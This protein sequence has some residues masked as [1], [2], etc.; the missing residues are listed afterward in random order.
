MNR[1][2]ALLGTG[3]LASLALVACGK[4]GDDTNSVGGK[5]DDVDGKVTQVDGTQ[6]DVEVLDNSF[7]D[8]NIQVKPGTKVIWTNDGQQDHDIVPVKGGQKFGIE[9][10]DFEAG[11]VYEFTFA[12]PGVYRYYCSLHGSADGGMTGA[13]IVK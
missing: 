7:N 11:D 6:A 10:G 5:T 8:E 12:K 4:D 3:L 2:F 1:A 13:V 9:A